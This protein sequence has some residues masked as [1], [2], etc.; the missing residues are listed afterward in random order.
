MISY[1]SSSLEWL[2]AGRVAGP[3]T[4]FRC[5]YLRRGVETIPLEIAKELNLSITLFW[6]LSSLS[7][8]YPPFS[9]LAVVQMD[10]IS[11]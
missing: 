8:L 7:F 1:S 3:Q 6:G 5:Q 9:L 2:L 10:G 11:R 4:L